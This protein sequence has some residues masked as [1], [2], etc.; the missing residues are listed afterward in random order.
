MPK[1][2]S[3]RD[4]KVMVYDSVKV[5]YMQSIKGFA[6]PCRFAE[7]TNC[8]MYGFFLDFCKERDQL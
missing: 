7:R 8:K 5:T 3:P 2:G 4:F 6:F 1:D